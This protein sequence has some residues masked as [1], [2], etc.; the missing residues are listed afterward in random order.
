MSSDAVGD[1]KVDVDD[2]AGDSEATELVIRPDVTVVVPVHNEAAYLPEALPRLIEEMAA[3]DADTRILVVENGSTD[4]SAELAE[5]LG[6]GRVEVLR[7]PEANYGAAIRA[8][9][10]SVETDWVVSFD[11]DY[12][13]GP[14]LSSAL[15]HADRSDIVIG[16]KRAPGSD[17]RRSA[18]RRFATWQL[19]T[20][21]RLMLGLKVSD[22]HGM[23]AVRRTVLDAVL[24]DVVSTRDLFDTELVVR[25][26][27][28]GFRISE[29]PVVVE[30]IRESK[31]PIWKRVPRTV[32]GIWKIRTAL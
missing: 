6:E 8:G 4:G 1:T 20:L 2:S 9:F 30:E 19:N 17:D 27:R 11:I 14:F 31:S 16:S 10:G 29:L 22:T 13:S 5:E 24:D 7:L 28:A 18:V 26:E 21:L 15:E 12:F 25:A 23:K 3:V 32:R